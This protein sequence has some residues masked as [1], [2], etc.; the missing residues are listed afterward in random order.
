MP[1]TILFGEHVESQDFTV[2]HDE[3]GGYGTTKWVYTGLFWINEGNIAEICKDLEEIRSNENY[4]GEIHFKEFQKSFSGEFSDKT[5]VAKGWFNLWKNKWSKKSF[6]NVLAVDTQHPMYQNSRFPKEFHAYN[7]FTL[8]A[9]KGGISWFFKNC[10]EINLDIYSDEKTRRAEGVIPDGIENDNFENYLKWQIE[11]QKEN[12]Q[13]VHIPENVKCMKCP[14]KGPYAPENELLQLTDL[15]LGSVST[16][17]EARANRETKIWFGKE[18]ARVM[19][20]IRL[21][22]WEQKFKLHRKFSLSYFPDEFGCIYENGPINIMGS[23]DKRQ[24]TLSFF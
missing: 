9:M 16:A 19:E 22:P 24:K 23:P 13:I 15:L 11:I 3:S 5:R 8:M 18:A 7:R 12:G 17:V 14:K 4:Y 2:Y 1:Q 20:D 10:S 21:K 6:F